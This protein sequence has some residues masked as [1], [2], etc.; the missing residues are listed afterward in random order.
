MP[1]TRLTCRPNSTSGSTSVGDDAAVRAVTAAPY[2][3]IDV[4]DQQ[5]FSDSVSAEI[6]KML[7]LIYA[8]LALAIVISLLGI[9]NTMALSIFERTRE[10]G[11][12]RAVGMSRPQLRATGAWE[13]R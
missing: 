12:L 10:L 7:G 2:R 6:D 4:L 13:A 8:L 11:L 3:T 9:A 1:S 5:Q